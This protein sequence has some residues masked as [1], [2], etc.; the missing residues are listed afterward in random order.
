VPEPCR[1]VHHATGGSEAAARHISSFLR[2]LDRVRRKPLYDKKGSYFIFGGL[3]PGS[4]G[5]LH[6]GVVT[7]PV[8]VLVSCFSHFCLTQVL[9]HTLPYRSADAIFHCAGHHRRRL[10]VVA[11][12]LPSCSCRYDTIPVTLILRPPSAAPGAHTFLSCPIP[13]AITVRPNRFFFFTSLP[14]L[15]DGRL[16]ALTNIALFLYVA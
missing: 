9:S 13:V 3:G 2:F 14:P 10:S 8:T 15:I 6:A 7:V 12:A 16:I 4:D 1:A 11:A 5:R